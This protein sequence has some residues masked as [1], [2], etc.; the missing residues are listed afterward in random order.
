MKLNRARR[1][2]LLAYG[3]L[4]VVL[5]VVL[6]PHRVE[7]TATSLRPTVRGAPERPPDRSEIVEYHPLWFRSGASLSGS[8]LLTFSTHGIA[9]SNLAVELVALT[10]VAAVAL[11]LS[12]GTAD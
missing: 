12:K 5:C 1:I 9:V 8:V 7:C 3:F 11:T 6:V 10:L 2:I 4:V